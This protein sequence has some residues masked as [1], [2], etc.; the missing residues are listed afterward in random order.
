MSRRK[1]IVFVTIS[2]LIVYILVYLVDPFIVSYF[3]I[4]GD[5]LHSG[6]LFTDTLGGF[7]NLIFVPLLT[8]VAMRFW[9]DEFRYWLT[10]IP[11]YVIMKFVFYPEGVY[12]NLF[13]LNNFNIDF[14]FAT[15]FVLQ[16][17]SWLIVKIL[18]IF[19]RKH[20][21]TKSSQ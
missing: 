17:L 4:G 21:I 11:V 16:I 19:D 2:Q 6:W 20:D 14:A 3:N 1:K 15:I 13:G 5:L 10:W 7:V 8:I 12:I 18:K 9:V